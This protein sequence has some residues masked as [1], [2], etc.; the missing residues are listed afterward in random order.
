M[1]E[2]GNCQ[3]HQISYAPSGALASASALHPRQKEIPRPVAPRPRGRRGCLPGAGSRGVAERAQ[4]LKKVERPG[5]QAGFTTG[6]PV[7]PPGAFVLSLE[8]GDHDPA[9]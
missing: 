5:C 1:A 8:D 6:K 4:D 9:L 3:P 7:F 2:G